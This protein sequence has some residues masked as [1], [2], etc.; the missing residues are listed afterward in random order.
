M[1][2]YYEFALVVV[3]VSILAL[4]LLRALGGAQRD[5]EEAGV[6]AEAAA[7]RTQL[8]ESVAHREAFGGQFPVS[9]NPMDWIASR[10]YNYIGEQRAMPQESGVWYFDINA[11]ILVYRFRDGHLARFRLSR[12]ASASNL[13]GVVAGIGLLRLDDKYE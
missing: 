1:R 13:R 4:V 7:I 11:K 2:R 6:Q 12:E 3:L 5:M 8:L 10:P 9:D